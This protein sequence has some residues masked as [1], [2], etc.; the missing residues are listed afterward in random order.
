MNRSFARGRSLLLATT[1]LLHAAPAT[2]RQDGP[3]QRAPF[4]ALRFDERGDA[5]ILLDG[6]WLRLRG[7]EGIAEP[8]L[9]RLA[10]HVAGEAWRRRL[11]EDLCWLLDQAGR[12][13]GPTMTLDVADPDGGSPR[14]LAEVPATRARREAVRDGLRAHLEDR[15]RAAEL[16]AWAGEVETAAIFAELLE[17]VRDHHAYASLRGL[18]LDALAAAEIA[19]LGPRPGWPAQL[20]AAQRLVAALGDGHAGVDPWRRAV[21]DVHLPFLVDEAEGGVVALRNDRS[22]FVDPQRPFLVALDGRDVEAWI[23]SAAELVPHGSPQLVRSRAIDGLR[24]AGL[25]RERL[26]LDAA[27][28]IEVALRGPG[29]AATASLSMRLTDR[30]PRTGTWPRRTTRRLPSGIAY[31]RL[32]SMTP[33]DRESEEAWSARLRREL[34]EAAG[35]PGIVIDVRGNGG[36]SRLPIRAMLPLMLA[37]D[38]APRVVAVARYRRDPLQAAEPESSYLSDRFMAPRDAPEWTDAERA[39]IDRFRTRFVPEWCPDDALLS[40]PHYMVVSPAPGP[41]APLPPIVVLQDERCFS[42]TDVFLAAI[43]GVP[44]VTRIGLPSAGG[45]AR[46]RFF[47]LERLGARVRLATMVSWQPDGRLFDGVG[48][49]PDVRVPRDAGD[50]VGAGDHQL[51]AAIA[52]LVGARAPVTP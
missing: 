9:R 5:T 2:A 27:P 21:P 28:A 36:G 34:L 45:S 47:P 38:A 4:D 43:G 17:V 49:A 31:L 26:G 48:V 33:R 13:P 44:G 41:R 3:A 42:A 29:D 1:L 25:L 8:D 10:R 6:A 46:S 24:D 32:D 19:A 7:V 12:A 52:F 35:A 14:R 16:R 51:D 22:G 40:V 30:R 11:G 18:D 20:L 39:A 37:A 50:L 15:E 23:A